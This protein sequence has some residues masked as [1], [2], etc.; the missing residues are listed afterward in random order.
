MLT[1][2]STTRTRVTGSAIVF[3]Q[4]VHYVVTPG[5]S[6]TKKTGRKVQKPRRPPGGTHDQHEQTNR[7]R[8]ECGSHNGCVSG[9]RFRDEPGRPRAESPR[10]GRARPIWRT[11]RTFWTRRTGRPDGPCADDARAAQPDER[12]TGSCETDHGLA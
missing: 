5:Q 11:G 6:N 8:P 1:S 7:T 12:S 2:S 4:T 10:G 9:R 3:S